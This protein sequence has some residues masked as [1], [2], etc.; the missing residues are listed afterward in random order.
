M[1]RNWIII[2]KRIE[3]LFLINHRLTN[4]FPSSPPTNR[5]EAPQVRR[6]R[7]GV[8][9]EL[10]S[11]HP[12]AQ[13]LG[14]QAVLLRPLRKVVPAEGGSASPPRKSTQQQLRRSRDAAPDEGR[15]D[16]QQQLLGR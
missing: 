5:R 14:L 3:E 8:Q 12:H 13:T 16:Q 2:L 10:E 11:H 15:G 1:P 7:K 6:L 9:P 4:Q